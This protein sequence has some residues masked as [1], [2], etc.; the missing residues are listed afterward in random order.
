M[1]K[2]TVYI[3]AITLLLLGGCN[4]EKE[5][6]PAYIHLESFDV[7]TDGT[8]GTAASKITDAWFSLKTEG[9]LGV[10]E[11][12]KT[13][14]VLAEGKTTMFIQPGI[15]TNG[16]NGTPD[17]YPFFEDQEVEV[18]LT[19]GETH[20]INLHTQYKS[21]VIFEYLEDFDGGNTLTIFPDT[22]AKA[23]V[24]TTSAGAFEGKSALFTLDE[25]HPIIQVASNKLMPRDNPDTSPIEGLPL[26]GGSSIFLEMH[27]KNEG[28]LQVGL[29]G[30][31]SG[32]TTPIRSFFIA[33]NPKGEWN[34]IYIN[35]TDELLS[36]SS[37]LENFQILF[38]ANLPEGQTS[39]T[40]QIDNLKVLHV[41][42]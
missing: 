34:K 11:L 28:V 2:I 19:P 35:L 9:F 31:K 42:I 10:Y 30:Y 21:S 39:A 18:D 22:S 25:N 15:K 1:K 37:D 17:I 5:P 26:Q 13:F 27:Y 36:T 6:I 12:P 29:V 20:N 4:Q 38:G 41:K 23:D 7:T 33:L 32:S 24:T 14:P 3:F 40:F 16:I 8:Q